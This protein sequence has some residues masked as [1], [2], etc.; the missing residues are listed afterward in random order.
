MATPR[1]AAVI[2]C[3]AVRA[4]I[5]DVIGSVGGEVTDIFVVD[6]GCPQQSGKLVEERCRDPRVRV[7]YHQENGGVGAAVVTGYKA[8]LEQHAD[9]VVKIDG[10]GQMNAALVPSLVRPII[11]KQADYVKGN[12]FF[13]LRHLESM[14]RLRLFGNAL[15]SFVNKAVSGYW[16]IMDPTNGFTAIH[17]FVLQQLPLDKLDRRYFFESDMLFRLSL[18][19]AVVAELP[20]PARYD[21]QH[22]N[23]RI[24]RVLLSFPL[25][26][27]T[28][29]CKRIF[30][31]YFLRDFNVGSLYLVV[32]GLLLIG[33]VVIGARAWLES[34]LTQTLATSG[35]VMLAALPIILGCQF[36]I[37]AVSFDIGNAPR[38]PIQTASRPAN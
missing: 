12:R 2:P 7:L 34:Y 33:G 5:L 19:R 37:A 16:Q 23:L 1:I 38:T 11:D 14:P 10:D 25:K 9:I 28:R 3:Y 30:Y 17:A 8:A 15:L 32:G 26:Y 35:T 31:L 4:T 29:F 22:S 13:A 18:V 27:M 6:D 21:G 36:L 20:M 24:G